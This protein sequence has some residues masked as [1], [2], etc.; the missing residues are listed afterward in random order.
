MFPGYSHIPMFSGNIERIATLSSL[1][2]LLQ[3]SWE[4]TVIVVYSL[5]LVYLQVILYNT[6]NNGRNTVFLV[7]IPVITIISGIL[8]YNTVIMAISKE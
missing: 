4:Y 2:G 6:R 3:Y 7:Y 8:E 5:L 1:A